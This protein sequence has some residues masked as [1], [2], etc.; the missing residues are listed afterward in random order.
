M[1]WPLF[2]TV[3]ALGI[4]LSSCVKP[5]KPEFKGVENINIQMQNMEVIH[6]TGDAV[7]HNPNSM[8]IHV[9]GT[10]ID[11]LVNDIEAGKLERNLDVVLVANDETAI[12][13]E[14]DLPTEKVFSNPLQMLGGALQ[15]LGGRTYTVQFKGTVAVKAAGITWN[16][17]I[18][19]TEEVSLMPS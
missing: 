5:Q 15:A 9:T 18:D 13:V 6:V 17:P 2:A 7:F 1:K 11:V 10:D 4:A 14:V 19:Q 8:D 12:F 3:I 16:L